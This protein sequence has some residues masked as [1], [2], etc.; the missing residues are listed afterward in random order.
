M[1]KI[2]MYSFRNLGRLCDLQGITMPSADKA[3]RL[4]STCLTLPLTVGKGHLLTLPLTEGKG[5]LLTLPL[6][7]G[8][9]H[10]LALPLT[11]GKGRLITLPLT[12]GKG[13]LPKAGTSGYL[14]PG[15]SMCILE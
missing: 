15:V 5:H 1:L 12:V 9:G 11:E 6:T 8:K 7:E 10:L 2:H 13:R 4:I 14:G 3:E